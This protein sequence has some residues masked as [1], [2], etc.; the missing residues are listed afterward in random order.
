MNSAEIPLIP[1]NIEYN[2]NIFCDISNQNCN[3]IYFNIHSLRK[4]LD[5]LISAFISSINYKIHVIV[6]TET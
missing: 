5:Q 4:K 2:K 3:I 6:L 1:I